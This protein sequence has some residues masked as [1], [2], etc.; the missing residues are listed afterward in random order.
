MNRDILNKQEAEYIRKLRILRY[1][2]DEIVDLI[3][4][5]RKSKDYNEVVD[6]QSNE[7]MFGYPLQG[8]IKR[9]KD[10]D[11]WVDTRSKEYKAP[12]GF[13]N[14]K[15]VLPMSYRW[16]SDDNGNPDIETIHNLCMV[17]SN[18]YFWFLLKF[19]QKARL[20]WLLY[21]N[22]S[23][24]LFGYIEPFYTFGD[25]LDDLN[26]YVF[27]RPNEQDVLSCIINLRTDKNET[28]PEQE[29]M[30]RNNIERIK[31]YELNENYFFE[32]VIA[33]RQIEQN[34]RPYRAFIYDFIKDWLEL[35]EIEDRHNLNCKPNIKAEHVFTCYSDKYNTIE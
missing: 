33:D 12:F 8:T 17:E 31:S 7:S 21:D 35:F 19:D 4:I 13:K 24:K 11:H 16:I 14:H 27:S 30:F 28:T 9:R 23:S 6:D 15:V 34:I 1:D 2:P 32:E 10:I 3:Y 26:Q 29:L 20:Y 22:Y 25:L 18:L 5:F